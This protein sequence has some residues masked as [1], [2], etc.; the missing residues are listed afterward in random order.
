M[1]SQLS[2]ARLE[3]HKQLVGQILTL[4]PSGIPSNADSSSTPSKTIATALAKR[5]FAVGSSPKL[6]GQ[7]SG[8][9][10]EEVC[11]DFIRSAWCLLEH[12]RPGEWTVDRL[13]SRN[14]L[15]LAAFDQYFHLK[16]L[17]D[18]VEKTPELSTVLGND[19]TVT[20]DIVVFRSP[21]TD[22]VINDTASIV[23]DSVALKTPFRAHNNDRAILH[24]TVSCKWT[25]RSDRAQNARSEALN[26]I[27][28]RRG[29]LPHIMIVTAEPTPNRIA[30]LALGTGDIDC[31][32][33]IALPELRESVIESGYEDS[34]ELLDTMING[35]RLR[36]I[37][38][39]PL[40]L[41]V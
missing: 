31:V 38:D 21:V 4:G 39:L 41:A 26:L 12:L 19:Y 18:F 2:A 27:R 17:A 16:M 33:H 24:A 20:P 14:Q 6:K 22:E 10:F 11:E 15:A 30:S 7:T 13:S 36:D 37:A 28:N 32:Y 40:D 35:R 1:S 3:F 9:L 25:I 29:N 8:R 34:L 5:L 23:D